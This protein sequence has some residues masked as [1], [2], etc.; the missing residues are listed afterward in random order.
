MID[1]YRPAMATI[2]TRLISTAV[3]SASLLACSLAGDVRPIEGFLVTVTTFGDCPQG[4]CDEMIIIESNG[5]VRRPGSDPPLGS[6]S[7]EILQAL[8]SAIE[9][10]DFEKLRNE[11]WEDL[12]ADGAAEPGL[13]MYDFFAEAGLQ[14]V[15]ACGTEID[16]SHPL[17][18]ALADTL[19]AVG[20][21]LP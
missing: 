5:L 7:P 19:R 9:T 14:R 18:V 21:P 15:V 3:L 10:T 6:L 1:C 4:V 11:P 2:G 20:R 12:C 13:A 17:F 8:T 16:R